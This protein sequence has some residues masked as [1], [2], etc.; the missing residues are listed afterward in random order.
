MHP[1]KQR[2]IRQAGKPE[3][4]LLPEDCRVLLE[5]IRIN[6][7]HLVHQFVKLRV[8]PVGV[9]GNL[10]RAPG[11]RTP[12]KVHRI[13]RLLKAAG[14]SGREGNVVLLG[15]QVPPVRWGRKAGVKAILLQLLSHNLGSGVPLLPRYERDR[16]LFAFGVRIH[17]VG[18]LGVARRLAPLGRLIEVELVGVVF[19]Q[20]VLNRLGVLYKASVGRVWHRVQ[21]IVALPSHIDDILAVDGVA[22]APAHVRA[23]EWRHCVVEPQRLRPPVRIAIGGF[24]ARVGS[25]LRVLF[26]GSA[27][28]VGTKMRNVNLIVDHQLGQLGR[29]TAGRNVDDPLHLDAIV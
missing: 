7:R 22:D 5:V 6:L 10:V 9:V 23:V 3:F 18:A 28:G 27:G 13:V 15:K 17:P 20:Q 29:R 26:D 25:D 14:V 4:R 16:D 11:A 21:G 2:D 24:A 12:I 8:T 1:V 19:L